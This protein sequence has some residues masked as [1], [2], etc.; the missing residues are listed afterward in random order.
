MRAISYLIL[1]NI[2]VIN[3]YTVVTANNNR[4][5]KEVLLLGNVMMLLSMNLTSSKVDVTGVSG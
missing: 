2:N 4:F 3:Y 5:Q 1:I